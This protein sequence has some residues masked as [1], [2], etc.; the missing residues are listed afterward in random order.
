MPVHY[1]L[2]SIDEHK[3]HS[4]ESRRE[5]SRSWCP[6]LDTDMTALRVSKPNI[7]IYVISHFKRLSILA[8]SNILQY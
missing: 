5:V 3:L 8:T 2:A 7:F 1:K 4:H 6:L